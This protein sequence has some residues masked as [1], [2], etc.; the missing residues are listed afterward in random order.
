MHKRFAYA[1]IYREIASY[2]AMTG[3]LI[4]IV[5]FLILPS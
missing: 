3:C 1:I 4:L 5:A 2:L